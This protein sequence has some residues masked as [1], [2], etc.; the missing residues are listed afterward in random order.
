MY[1][2]YKRKEKKHY[3]LKIRPQLLMEFFLLES[4][5]PDF[6]DI[7]GDNCQKYIVNEWCSTFGG[8]GTGWDESYGTF[9]DFAVNGKTAAVCPQCGCGGGNLMY[10]NYEIKEKH[11][12]SLF[13]E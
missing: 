6:V 12:Y 4:C 2:Y 11:H 1:H 13:W 5:N 7:D 10:C 8:N 9:E 3:C